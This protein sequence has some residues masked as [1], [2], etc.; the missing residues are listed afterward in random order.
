MDSHPM[1]SGAKEVWC[2]ICG[3][4]VL[5]DQGGC[6]ACGSADCV[7]MQHFTSIFEAGRIYER[8]F[9]AGATPV[10]DAL[11]ELGRK[12]EQLDRLRALVSKAD[13]CTGCEDDC[14]RCPANRRLWK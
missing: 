4:R 12:S 9:K 8:S 7:P 2:P 10:S 3:P 5:A 13:L 1:P 14:S 6:T 11:A